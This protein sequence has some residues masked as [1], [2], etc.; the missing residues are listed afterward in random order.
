MQ[1]LDDLLAEAEGQQPTGGMDLDAL[2]TEAE[3]SQPSEPE[4]STFGW[5]ADKGESLIRGA[6][7][8][9][10]DMADLPI[11]M[12]NLATGTGFEAYNAL[13]D[14]D[15][16]TDTLKMKPFSK[17]LDS[18]TGG[19][20]EDATGRRVPK[21]ESGGDD[22]AYT[23]GEFG[24]GAGLPVAGAAAKAPKLA[25][26]LR[27][28]ATDVG[29]GLGAATGGA[30]FD[31]NEYAELAGSFAPL[32]MGKAGNISESGKKF[33]EGLK[34]D[35]ANVTK[36]AA[37][38]I[39]MQFDD[40]HLAV[41]NAKYELNQ[42]TKGALANITGD[43]GAFNAQE[44][45]NMNSPSGQTVQRVNAER[46]EQIIDQLRQTG[47]Q[48]PM[49]LDEVLDPVQQE[50]LAAVDTRQQ[51]DVAQQEQLM[52]QEIQAS[53]LRQQNLA[54]QQAAELVAKE[55]TQAD[56]NAAEIASAEATLAAGTKVT[57]SQASKELTDVWTAEQ[58]AAYAND[59]QPLY[60]EF[61][62]T[63]I[64]VQVVADIKNVVTN[65]SIAGKG[66]DDAGWATATSD[67]GIKEILKRV[68]DWEG[69]VKGLNVQTLIRKAKDIRHDAS[70]AVVGK[71]RDTEVYTVAD[72]L[73]K[74]MESKLTSASPKYAEANAANTQYKNT[75]APDVY[76]DLVKNDTPTEEIAGKFL[77]AKE[78]GATTGSVL[79][80]TK[81]K[82]V[83]AGFEHYL[84]SV[85]GA[86]G[87]DAGFMKKYDEL[88]TAFPESK[89][90]MEDALAKQNAL[91]ESER[92]NVAQQG[93]TTE[94]VE[95][96][97]TGAVAEAK[98]R[99]VTLPKALEQSKKSLESAAG[100]AKTGL[101]QTRIAKFLKDPKAQ[102]RK[103]ITGDDRV[104][105][106]DELLADIDG[107]DGAKVA[108]KEALFNRVSELKTRKL[109]DTKQFT[110][111]FESSVG[112]LTQ[113][114]LDRGIL[115]KADSD[116]VGELIGRVTS[117]RM[118]KDA[119]A[120]ALTQMPQFKRVLSSV[121]A[122][123]LLKGSGQNSLIL[124][125]SMRRM[126][127]SA[128][129]FKGK[130]TPSVRAEMDRLFA[131]P[132]EFLKHV[133]FPKQKMVQREADEFIE[134]LFKA[135]GDVRRS[136]GRVTQT[137]KDE[138]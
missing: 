15:V 137:V 86:D 67:T 96:H 110:D 122:M 60:A 123:S 16:P 64:P 93:R 35:T 99:E 108:L 114:L 133:K 113:T 18:V 138:E 4:Q 32:I 73:V 128:T 127:L 117:D 2:L 135:E 24:G 47:E 19:F 42:G 34:G 100:K 49:G 25:N 104:K 26:L 11:T 63:D 82:D 76:T 68:D 3:Q 126:F 95:A 20:V 132:E 17:A 120:P 85:A 75:I 102:I 33:V 29:M 43:A 62:A 90:L 136:V 70:G 130:Q 8:G 109:G 115:T 44:A 118:A 92:V 103:L 30:V 97:T 12:A 69:G 65:P 13:T 38:N 119:R 131:N 56:V 48:A 106:L 1:T 61:E 66:L 94:A 5:I 9:M 10:M 134:R 23:F 28:G 72:N 58:K 7:K 71:S 37:E 112:E 53:Q 54:D 40:A 124:A 51:A 80:K 36:A 14:S 125:N 31:G 121:A 78:K 59:V 57:P 6:N 21:G 52:Q 50:R 45:V 116:K 88:L 105:R 101:A 84:R 41:N 98:Q 55:Q 83:N 74:Q 39:M 129:G 77:G 27:A 87:I 107:I 22:F 79:A 89:A 46:N 111:D 81:S 91:K